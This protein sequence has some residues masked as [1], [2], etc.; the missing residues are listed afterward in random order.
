MIR[1]TITYT[2]YSDTERTKTFNFNLSKLEIVENEDLAEGFE[3]L[4]KALTDEKRTEQNLTE[5]EGR[6]VFRLVRRMVE[7]SYGER[8]GEYFR[9]SPQILQN[10][11]DSGAYEAFLF[12]TFQVPERALAFM[13]ELIPSD[14]LEEA[15]KQMAAN[16]QATEAE[17][18]TQIEGSETK[19][20]PSDYSR[21]QLLA[22]SDEEF[23]AIAGDEPM[24]MSRD[25]LNIAFQRK[26]A[27]KSE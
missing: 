16:E 17:L 15:K 3:E 8:E 13:T 25:L 21:E 18:P 12:H 26:A 1:E 9:K 23:T 10:F 5:E 7:L 20:V 6:S 24:K 4:V 2:D 14:T 27:A 11:I 19:L 22:M